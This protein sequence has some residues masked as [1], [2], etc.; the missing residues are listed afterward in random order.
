MTNAQFKKKVK[1]CM[2][3]DKAHI[4]RLIDKAIASGCMDIS[5]AED[6]YIL[7]KALITAIYREMS[8]QYHPLDHMKAAKK[9]VENIYN[10]L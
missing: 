5:G 8:R 6:N 7:P 2:K 10:H 9:E 1:D 4:D 3:S